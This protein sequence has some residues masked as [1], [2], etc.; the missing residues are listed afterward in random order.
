MPAKKIRI[1]DIITGKYVHGNREEMKPSYLITSYGLKLS[2]VNLIGS[3]VEKFISEDGS[4]ASL[5]LDDGTSSIKIKAFKE[6]VKLFDVIE[7]GDIVNVVGK[8]KEFNGETYIT[9]EILRKVADPNFEILRRLEILEEIVERKKMVEEIKNVRESMSTEELKNYLLN[10]YGMDSETFEY[11]LGNLN[12]ESNIDYKPKVL[13]LIQS[14]DEGD[15]V[16]IAK[17]F[18]ISNLP[19]KILESTISDLLDSGELFEPVAGRLRRV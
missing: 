13:E 14:L 2:R 5:T 19:D 7:A 18:E 15:G 12:L 10:K 17:I 4:F 6:D 8:V 16:E 3:I 11:V 1:F 9:S